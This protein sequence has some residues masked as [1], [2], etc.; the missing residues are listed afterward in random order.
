MMSASRIS[1]GSVR[2]ESFDPV[3]QIGAAIDQDRCALP[4]AVRFPGSSLPVPD[5]VEDHQRHSCETADDATA[6]ESGEQS[7]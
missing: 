7:G 4:R 6:D 5:T 3:R 2:R 1:A